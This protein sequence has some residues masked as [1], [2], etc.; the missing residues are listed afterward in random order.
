M[1]SRG[2]PVLSASHGGH[3]RRAPSL[4]AM[5]RVVV[6]VIAAVALAVLSV[7]PATGI[8]S[9]SSTAS[10]AEDTTITRYDADFQVAANGDMAVTETLTVDFPGVGKHGIFRFF[11]RHDPSAPR[12]LR[13]PHDISVTMDGHPEPFEISHQSHDRYVV[14]R[15]GDPNVTIGL[16]AHTYVI[17]YQIDGVLEPGSNGAETQFYWNLIPGGWAQFIR[18]VHLVVHLPVV[19]TYAKC[20]LGAGAVGHCKVAGK[21]TDTL[22]IDGRGVPPYT[23]L[24][25]KAGLPI[26]T[27]PAGESLPWPAKWEPVLGDSWGGLLTV[28]ILALAA[29][30]AGMAL[31]GRSFERKPA[32]PVQYAPPPDVGPAEAAYVVTEK[33]DQ[34]A[35]VASM[36]WAAQQGAIELS[37][38][39]DSWTITDKAGPEGWAKLDRATAAVAPLLGGA[40]GQFT[41][42]QRDVSSGLILQKRIAA[43]QKETR[44]WG[45]SNGFLA[46]TGLGGLGGILVI[47]AAIVAGYAAARDLVR[48][49]HHRPHPRRVRADRLAA[50][51]PDGRDAAY[52]EGA[53]PVVAARRLRT[54][55]VDAVEQ[56]ALR[57]LRAAGPLHRLH[58]VGG[59]LRLRGRVGEEVPH[60]DGHRAAG[61]GVLRR[62]LRRRPHR[63]LRQ[64]DGA[65]LLVHGRQ[66]DLGVPGHA[67]PQQRRRG[68]FLRRR[69]WRR[70]WRGLLVTAMMCTR[71]GKDPRAC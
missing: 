11:D 56:A 27:P 71:P 25:L 69:W 7:L 59:G 18:D 1:A 49:E 26:A 5:K 8:Q 42:K 19:P 64:P 53:R 30:A 4:T 70:R 50:A 47:A 66:L 21:D 17:R 35:F 55:A 58:P 54:D 52:S 62:L 10:G 14:A 40:G 37:R 31:A 61:A 12:A 15:I 20:A 65:R 16:S 34:Q 57:L 36:L 13:T 23:P 2:R 39:G 22:T 43:F 44:D 48:H 68:R 45:L 41:A 60:G 24:T 67:V 3:T 51:G 63:R 6:T 9:D 32:F 28:L 38:D 46:K 33:V 29:G